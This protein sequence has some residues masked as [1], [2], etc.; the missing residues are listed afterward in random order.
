MLGVFKVAFIAGVAAHIHRKKR[1][2]LFGAC[3]LLL[4]FRHGV[5]GVGQ[6]FFCVNACIIHT[7]FFCAHVLCLF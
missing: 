7:R 3:K 4:H 6:Q 2:Y 5:P 1:Q